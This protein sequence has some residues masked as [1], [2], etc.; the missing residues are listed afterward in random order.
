MRQLQLLLAVFLT[1]SLMTP[2][3]WA[4]ESWAPEQKQVLEA[5][6]R[7]SATTAPGGGGADA[8]GA[9]LAEDFSRWTIGS[10]VINRKA[11]WVDGLREWLDA[12]WRVSD[13]ETQTL[14]IHVS[15]EIAYARRVVKETYTGPDGNSSVSSAALAEVWV[16]SKS[17]WLLT[18]VDLHPM[19]D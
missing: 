9:I 17:G 6:E 7:L 13:R 1:L 12:G 15:G 3:A 10:K 8:Y 16:R 18:R 5:I 19:G 2:L 11:A 14:E 4:E